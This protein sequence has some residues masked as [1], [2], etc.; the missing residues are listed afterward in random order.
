MQN[1]SNAMQWWQD[2]WEMGT[3]NNIT[4]YDSK[5]MSRQQGAKDEWKENDQKNQ[6][7]V[8]VFTPQYEQHA[9]C[10]PLSVLCACNWTGKN[11]EGGDE[12][13]RKA[14]ELYAWPIA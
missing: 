8:I 2:E 10:T 12:K 3:N 11:I 7:A 13:E 1:E 4:Q 14:Q 6:M 9:H 5:Q